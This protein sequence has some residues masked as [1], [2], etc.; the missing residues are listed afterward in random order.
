[1]KASRADS[2]RRKDHRRGGSRR[3]IDREHRVERAVVQGDVAVG[4]RGGAHVRA[5]LDAVGDHAVLDARQRLHALDNDA[6]RARAADLRAH[7]VE[8]AGE[9]DNLGLARGGFDRGDAAGQGRGGHD[10]GGAEHRG[11][12]GPA[13]EHAGPLEAAVGGGLGGDI[14]LVEGDLG[15]QCREPAEVQVDGAV[16]DGAA[17]GH[18]HPCNTATGEHGTEHADAGPHGAD[19][20]VAGVGVGLVGG[21]EAE[22]APGGVDAGVGEVARIAP[23]LGEQAAEVGD[24]GEVRD[25]GE[26]DG[27]VGEQ[28]RGHQGERGVLGALDGET[29]GKSGRALDDETVHGRALPNGR[30]GMVKR[31][32]RL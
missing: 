24:V 10:V 11:P 5:C 13:Q 2:R 19:D 17:A 21:L 30:W 3:R 9:V 1:M 14:A 23:Q 4:H 18:R 20:V 15:A 29:T 32:F 7:G 31:R 28:G 6:G 16:A 25:V 27:L 22:Q 26:L 12:E 8:H